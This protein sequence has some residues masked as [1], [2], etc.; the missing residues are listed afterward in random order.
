AGHPRRG[1]MLVA[2]DLLAIPMSLLWFGFAIFWERT[3]LA[4]QGPGFV[5]LWG[6]P[7]V[8]MGLYIVFGRFFV[9]ALRRGKTTYGL[10]SRRLILVS[11]IFSRQ[12]KSIELASLGHISLTE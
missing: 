2:A 8:A 12:V 10:T 3:A 5:A 7:F 11:G 4:A 9:D 6:V 1:F